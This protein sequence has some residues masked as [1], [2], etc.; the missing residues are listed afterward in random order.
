[1]WTCT[2]SIVGTASIAR[3]LKKGYFM[4]GKIAITFDELVKICGKRFI[5]KTVDYC[6]RM[7][8][9]GAWD[10]SICTKSHCFFW[11][12][13]GRANI[14]KQNGHIAQ[15]AKTE[16]DAIALCKEFSE[17]YDCDSVGISLQLSDN[18]ISLTVY[19]PTFAWTRSLPMR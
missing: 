14:K 11:R 16:S 15:L 8:L 10:G 5:D 6:G 2:V 18:I 19:S 9:P 13:I 3:T 1:M 17:I 4:R 7:D 12:T